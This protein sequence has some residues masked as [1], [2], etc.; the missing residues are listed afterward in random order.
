[1]SST[2][3]IVVELL[4]PRTSSKVASLSVTRKTTSMKVLRGSLGTRNTFCGV[5]VERSTSKLPSS[6]N[7]LGYVRCCIERTIPV[8]EP[9]TLSTSE[10]S[11][12]RS[13]ST[14]TTPCTLT[15]SF[16]VCSS[17]TTISSNAS[18][19]LSFSSIAS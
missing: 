14:G 1:M 12:C 17:S 5:T 2:Y 8:T 7:K 18:S 11:G 9:A 16:L 6:T 13:L 10:P 19:K 4:T 15:S 3:G